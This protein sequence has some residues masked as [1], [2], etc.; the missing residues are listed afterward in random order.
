MVEFHICQNPAVVGRTRKKAHFCNR[1]G[2]LWVE[3]DAVDPDVRAPEAIINFSFLGELLQIKLTPA[4]QS[5][6]A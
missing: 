4:M 6:P 3:D 5:R 1:N 2:A